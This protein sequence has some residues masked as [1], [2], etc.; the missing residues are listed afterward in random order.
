MACGLYLVLGGKVFHGW[1]WVLEIE[2]RYKRAGFEE[3]PRHE[4]GGPEMTH[5]S[6]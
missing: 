1:I 6:R 4:N 3:A 5:P 2:A